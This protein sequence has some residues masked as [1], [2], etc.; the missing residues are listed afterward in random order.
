MC[1][2]ATH[3]I[4]SLLSCGGMSV[5]QHA[6]FKHRQLIHCFDCSVYSIILQNKG[7]SLTMALLRI[8]AALL[9]FL[10]VPLQKF[11]VYLGACINTVGVYF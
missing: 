2:K 1:K 6:A 9:N 3:E 8:K 5:I 11:T 7:L 10:K 4:F